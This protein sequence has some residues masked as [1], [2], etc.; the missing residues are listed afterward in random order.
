MATPIRKSAKAAPPRKGQYKGSGPSR[1]QW[2]GTRWVSSPVSLVGG[3]MNRGGTKANT[4]SS[5]PKASTAKANDAKA[6]NAR[7]KKERE[8]REKAASRSSGGNNSHIL[9]EAPPSSPRSSSSTSSSRTTS[10]SSARA[11][12]AAQSS[13]MSANY[14]AWAKAHPELAKKVKKGSAGYDAING[15]SSSTS[16][17]G[18]KG[19]GPISSGADYAANVEGSRRPANRSAQWLKDNFK[20]NG[21]D[22][23][24]GVRRGIRAGA[25]TDKSN[26]ASQAAKQYKSGNTFGAYDGGGGNV[27]HGSTKDFAPKR[28][29]LKEA[30][31]S[32]TSKWDEK[33]RKYRTDGYF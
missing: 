1:K 24:A 26:Q 27:G 19:T 12:R 10:G 33:K 20:P 3:S 6:I 29:S 28:P 15:T 9:R 4:R 25:A 5:S 7:L 31:R 21:T 13:D 30:L 22:A 8:A 17:D 32:I 16:S 14:K 18:V 11:S 23:K 2:N